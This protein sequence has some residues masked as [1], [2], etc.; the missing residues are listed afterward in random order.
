MS[1]LSQLTFSA[2]A[3]SAA[4][5]IFA[6]A[7]DGADLGS[8]SDPSTDPDAGDLDSGI[9]ATDTASTQPAHDSAPPPV[10]SALP[11]PDDSGTGDADPP[12][13]P[14]PP[15]GGTGTE[16]DVS[17]PIGAVYYFYELTKASSPTSCPCSAATDCCYSSVQVCLK[18]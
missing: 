12:P 9:T 4:L 13:P 3:F 18:R 17:N 5:A 8:G 7:Q 1:R 15:D 11:P 6:C 10:D 2:L 16:C 14:P